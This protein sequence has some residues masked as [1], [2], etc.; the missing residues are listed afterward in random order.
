LSGESSNQISVA[1]PV[2]QQVRA[3]NARSIDAFL[4]PYHPD[5]ELYDLKVGELMMKGHE[6]MRSKFQQLFDES[7][8]LH[9]K[10]TNRMVQGNMVIDHETVTGFRG[11][12]T[13][14]VIAIHEVI[15]QLIT[16]VW[17]TR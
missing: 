3:Y 13:S 6:A 12:N 15:D 16:R 2:D 17:F 10:V 5:V 4:A 7:P 1:D 9:T 14:Y 8:D 11:D